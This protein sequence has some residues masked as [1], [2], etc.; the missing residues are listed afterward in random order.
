MSERNLEFEIDEIKKQL[1][2]LKAGDMKMILEF[3]AQNGA[4]GKAESK[5]HIGHVVK[6]PDMHPLPEIQAVLDRLENSCGE[7]GETGRVTYVGVFASGG[8]QSTWVKNEKSTD[9]LLN[10]IETGMAGKVLNCIGSNDR[11]NILLS[12]LKKPMTVAEL[13]TDGGYNSTGQVYHHL[14]PLIAADLVKEDDNAAKGTYFVQPHKV[15]G[16]IMLLAGIS[17]M[18]DEEYSKGSW[19]E[20]V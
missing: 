13:V 6:I 9:E 4:S 8:R 12:I 5:K 14:K 10:L 18:V 2:G 20:M 11:L 19:E 15:Q 7:N 16:I 3:I 17:D 1:E